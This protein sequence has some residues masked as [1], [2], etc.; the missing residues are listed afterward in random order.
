MK[1]VEETNSQSV[2]NGYQVRRVNGFSSQLALPE[3]PTE[4]S[5][6]IDLRS[7]TL[8]TL[9]TLDIPLRSFETQSL[10]SAKSHTIDAKKKKYGAFRKLI[11]SFRGKKHK[12]A[13]E[14]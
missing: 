3:I 14:N 7:S 1:I 2:S 4:S 12:I 8:D 5:S 11:N 6:L 10:S 9:D 13:V